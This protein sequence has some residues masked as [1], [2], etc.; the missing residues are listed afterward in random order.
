MP[1]KERMLISLEGR[2]DE[3]KMEVLEYAESLEPKEL[4]DWLNAMEFFFEW[5]PM[6]KVKFASTKLKVHT[7]IW[8]DH[9]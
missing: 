3:I 6:T 9:V 8:W 5:K 7:M 1:F 4:I 2:N